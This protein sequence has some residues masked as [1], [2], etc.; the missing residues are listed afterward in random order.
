MLSRWS[1]DPPSGAIRMAAE[2][3]PEC[4]AENSQES[5]WR[6][7]LA[8]RVEAYRVRRRR[9][10]P[11]AAQSRLP[12]AEPV[13]AVAHEH[14]SVAVA[15]P[16][17]SGEEDFAFT[18][19]IGRVAAE[20]PVDGRMVIDVSIPG[21]A[22]S[23]PRETEE[24]RTAGLYPVA[25]LGSRRI[26]GIIDAVCLLFAC[27]AFLALFSSLGGQFTLS[28]MSAAVYVAIFAVVYL[29][30]FALLHG[31]RRDDTGNDVSRAAGGE[32]FGRRSHTATDAAAQR[33][34]PIVGGNVLYGIF[35]G[36]VGR[37]RTDLARPVFANVFKR[38]ANL[39]GDRDAH[40]GSSA[41]LEVRV[42]EIAKRAMR[43]ADAPAADSRSFRRGF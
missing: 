23:T 38:G 16:P 19:A 25:P 7:E 27:G 1:A 18:I 3:L 13:A 6:G 20:R 35:L 36:A 42:R 10:A 32:F 26:A 40:G 22:E 24:R 8:N 5:T 11:D 28:K 43:S 31:L 37:G 14:V 29:Q 41:S 9:V 39:C 30:Y 4:A 12:F 15:E 17:V 34:L 2:A 33:R 21:D